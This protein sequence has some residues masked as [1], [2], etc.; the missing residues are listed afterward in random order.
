MNNNPNMSKNP[1]KTLAIYCGICS[2]IITKNQ[3]KIECQ[4]CKCKI[5][6]SCN[7]INLE[8]FKKNK[9]E[10]NLQTCINCKTNFP[11]QGLSN[12]QLCVE[13]NCNSFPTT[14]HKCQCAVCNKIISKN[15]RTILCSLCNKQTHIKCNHTDVKT[16]NKLINDNLPQICYICQTRNSSQ[17][18]NTN[19]KTNCGICNK[20]IAK[21]S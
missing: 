6:L 17:T 15:H 2:N 18:L 11:F 1:Q 21:K 7:E 16:Y 12:I 14:V 4:F 19:Q 10:T 3:H 9:G 5:H 8:T 13:N 20:N